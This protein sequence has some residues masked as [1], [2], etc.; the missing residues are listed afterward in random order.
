MDRDELFTEPGDELVPDPDE[1]SVE[2][3]LEGE[4]DDDEQRLTRRDK[5]NL[6]FKEFEKRAEEAERK[7]EEAMRRASEAERRAS[8][9]DT[10]AA[11]QKPPAID[12]YQKAMDDAYDRKLSA[13][14][15]YGE[16]LRNESLT[17]ERRADLLQKARSADDD[18]NRQLFQ[19][20]LTK[21]SKKSQEDPNL[22]AL[23]H[24]YPDVMFDPRA[25]RYAYG[26]YQRR[27][28]LYPDKSEDQL[29]EE[30]VQDTRKQLRIGP[31][32]QG[33][34]NSRQK[35]YGTTRGAVAAGRDK[36]RTIN[37]REHPHILRMAN[38]MYSHIPDERKRLETWVKENGS[39]YLKELEAE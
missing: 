7:A 20:E 4:D 12:P 38:E 18:Y 5:K 37:L 27:K 17:D 16:A 25:A 36:P 19:Q 21:H 13:W 10:I 3:P 34:P 32:S 23:K 39:Q 6:R 26:E 31:F 24:K 14:Q 8:I 1:I 22:V 35:F 33:S 11:F 30:A 29:V 15:M 28:V 9:A 2:P